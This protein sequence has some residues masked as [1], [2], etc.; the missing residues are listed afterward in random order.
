[1]IDLGGEIV[2]PQGNSEQ[3]PDPGHD[4]VAI[5]DARPGLDQE[6]LEPAN[7][8]RRRRLAHSGRLV[9]SGGS[10]MITHLRTPKS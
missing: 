6:E 10:L 8:V 9:I 1:M 2:P 3:E 7:I 5:D 4:P